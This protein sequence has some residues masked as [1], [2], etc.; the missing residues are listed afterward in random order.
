MKASRIITVLLGVAMVAAGIYCLCNPAM[1]T[2]SL[3]YVV[4][5][6]MIVDAI[7]GILLWRGRRALGFADGWTLAAAIASLVF[8]IV[9]TGSAALQLAVD[10]TIV[11]MAAIWLIV[12]GIMRVIF[13]LRIHRARAVTGV[14]MLGRRWWVLLLVGLLLI[15][16]GIF[17]LANPS[18]LI[19]AI[20]TI[21][22]LSILVAGLNLIAFA[23]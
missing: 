7:S 21:F 11:Y 15:A 19:V 6:T 9:L 20:G 17:S 3:G 8:G 2:L 23:A 1:T 22:G 5:V 16:C 13:A 14:Q 12:I 10:M 18:G 4:G